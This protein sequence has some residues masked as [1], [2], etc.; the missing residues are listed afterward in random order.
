MATGSVQRLNCLVRNMRQMAL[1]HNPNSLSDSRLL[2][3]FLAC[4]D[5]AAFELL[6]KRHGPMVLGVCR[7]VIGNLHDA[8]DA[9]QAVFLVLA[10][11][12]SSVTPRELVGNWLYGVAYRTALH[13]RARVQRQR[14]HERQVTDMPEAT[15]A[16][17][18]DITELH[19]VLDHELSRLP[20][21]YRLPIVLCE[22]EG[23]SR[24]VVAGTL[25]IPEGTLSSRMA[26]ARQ[27]LAQRLARHGFAL[28][29][30]ALATVLAIQ[31]AS[32]APPALVGATVKAAV[33][34]AAGRSVAGL[35]TNDVIALS[36]GALKTMFL[37]RIKVLSVL[38]LGVVLGALGAAGLAGVGT[39]PALQAAAPNH[40]G[41]SDQTKQP[42]ADAAE[43]LDG[44]LLL[45]KYIQKELRLSENQIKRIREISQD[46]DAKNSSQRDEIQQ[47]T[48]QIEELQKRVTDLQ[49]GIENK[50]TQSLA[51]AAPEFLSTQ[52][53]ARLRQIQRQQRSLDQ[54][55]ADA[56]CQRALK[57]DDE[58]V[59]KIEAILKAEP[60]IFYMDDLYYFA[61]QWASAEST[62]LRASSKSQNQKT[63]R[64][65]V[66]VLT[67]AQQRV[68]EDWIGEP[69]WSNS[70]WQVLRGKE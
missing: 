1:L 3:S 70:S 37:N 30:G 41:Q 6:V 58:Q 51:K 49:A 69:Y 25:K 48:K 20:D 4:R 28:S 21:K 65:L 19:Q 63:L 14:T 23:R 42:P 46:V 66:D 52:A 2:E 5:E 34:T 38:V 47:L 26:K 50:R 17:A 11:K 22:L 9:F 7:R 39:A 16:P 67:P 68:L 8:E 40:A 54:M 43:P 57:L 15:A 10:R 29:G 44:N 24:K 59:K 32:A 12:A 35:V 27:L 31:G 53:V 55:L 36:E 18:A 60:V 45:S 61:G 56:T 33:L 64:K 13:A 62:A